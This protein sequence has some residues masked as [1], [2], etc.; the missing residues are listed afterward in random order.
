MWHS[1]VFDF[2]SQVLQCSRSFSLR[3]KGQK[4]KEGGKTWGGEV[5]GLGL[6]W[7]MGG[8]GAR[9]QWVGGPGGWGVEKE[10]GEMWG[11]EKRQKRKSGA[12]VR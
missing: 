10:M 5:V 1:H 11:K 7:N 9:H 6:G 12:G 2:Y 8:C 4:S 3:G